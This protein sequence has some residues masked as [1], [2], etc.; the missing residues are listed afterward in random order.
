MTGTQQIIF[1]VLLI[2]TVV[3]VVAQE[4]TE[5]GAVLTWIKQLFEKEVVHLCPEVRGRVLDNGNPIVGVTI[6]RELS[7]NDYGSIKDFTVTDVDGYF[8][9][10]EKIMKKSPYKMEITHHHISQLI[11]VVDKEKKYKKESSQTLY[12]LWNVTKKHIGKD[13]SFIEKLKSLECDVNSKEYYFAFNYRPDWAVE[14][15]YRYQNSGTSI[16]RWT[17]NFKLYDEVKRD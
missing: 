8:S 15:K 3:A 5:G 4:R 7:Y 11:A 13:E 12:P 10:P 6:M 9:L 16:C 14:E 2:L 17:N 1:M